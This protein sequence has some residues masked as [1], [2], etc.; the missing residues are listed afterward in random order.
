FSWR[1]KDRF[2][3]IERKRLELYVERVHEKGAQ[4]RFWKIPDQNRPI[5]ERSWRLLLSSGV[6]IIATDHME[7]LHEYLTKWRN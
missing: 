1:G 2:L 7:H 4:L 3:S 5:R 6:D